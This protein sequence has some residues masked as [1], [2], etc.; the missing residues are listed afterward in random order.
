MSAGDLSPAPSSQASPTPSRRALLRLALAGAAVGAFAGGLGPAP[1][2]PSAAARPATEAAGR[3]GSPLPDTITATAPD[4]FP[5]GVAWDPT[6]KAFLVGSALQG[7]LSVVT[8]DGVVTPLVA[9]FA[10]VSVLGV[11]VDLPRGRVLAAYNN[12]FLRAAG[13]DL[14]P[15]SGVGVFDLATGAVRRLV[16]ISAGSADSAANDLAV[17][18]HGT[19]HVTDSIASTITHVD[20]LGVTGTVTDPRFPSPGTGLN[21][22][23]AHP[24]GFLVVSRFV[25]GPLFRV[26]P[27]R[28][29][30]P[31]QVTEVRLDR[32]VSH[33][34]GLG[35]RPDGSLVGVMNDLEPRPDGLPGRDAVLVLRSRDNWRR[36]HTASDR[37]W[38]VPDPTTVAVTPHGD[39][40]LSGQ[41]R[42]LVTGVPSPTPGVF[43][44]RR[45]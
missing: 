45:H 22:I 28:P 35:L 6:R 39:Y 30:R 20:R 8:P 24:A 23:V 15:L 43:H 17:D 36:A 1:L 18:A 16:D 31:A 38:P 2:V 41:I 37:P 13:Y 27:A 34:D 42:N 19:V 10:P 26:V 32:P 5:E 44:L 7:T 25:G 29:G 14:P 12:Y 21:G 11:H 4:L 40:V 33:L 3:F 9:N